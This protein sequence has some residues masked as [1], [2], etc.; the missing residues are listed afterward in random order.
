VHCS[1]RIAL[2]TRTTGAMGDNAAAGRA[3][4]GRYALCALVTLSMDSNSCPCARTPHIEHLQVVFGSQLASAR[5]GRSPASPARGERESGWR[6][7]QVMKVSS[8]LDHQAKNGLNQS[9]PWKVM[10]I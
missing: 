4:G 1:R 3:T 10:A 7:D 6:D 9:S 8:L 2:T 5:V